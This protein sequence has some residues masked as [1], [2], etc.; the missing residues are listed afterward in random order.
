MITETLMYK[1]HFSGGVAKEWRHWI[2]GWRCSFRWYL[3]NTHKP[4]RLYLPNPI[5]WAW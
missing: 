4:Y 2:L 5:K 1:L 3:P